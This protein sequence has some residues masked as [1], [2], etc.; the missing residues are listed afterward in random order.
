MNLVKR[1]ERKI[2]MDIISKLIAGIIER[3]CKNWIT[4]IV[5]VASVIIYAVNMFGGMIPPQYQAHVGLAVTLVAGV[6]LVLAKDSGLPASSIPTV[7][8]LGAM[9]LLFAC[10]GTLRA[11]TVAPTPVANG[12]AA[13]SDAVAIYYGGAWS[14]GTHVTESYD[15]LDFGAAKASHL[16]VEGHELI[17]PTPGFNIYAGGVKIEPDLSALL[18]KTNLPASNFGV[19]FDVALGNGLPSSGG[20][21]ISFLAGGGVKYNLTQSL[22]WQSLQAQYGQYGSNRFAAISTGL[23]FIF[24]K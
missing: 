8:K 24:A 7:G 3:S 16:Y 12:F 15:F 21:H 22:T 11:Q 4:T 19:S 18:K 1:A 10:A 20:S 23:S 6:A 14:A 17:A 13:A 2:E 5:G 9:L